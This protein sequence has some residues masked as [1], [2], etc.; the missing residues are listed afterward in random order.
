MELERDKVRGGGEGSGGGM[1]NTS[2]LE[3]RDLE[4]R[5]AVVCDFDRARRSDLDGEES[6]EYECWLYG[7]PA[8][9]FERVRMPVEVVLIP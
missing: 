1:G 2:S 8:L 5:W 3:V 9:E 4:Y 7:A 6:G